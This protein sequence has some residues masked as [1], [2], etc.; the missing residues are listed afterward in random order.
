MQRMLRFNSEFLYAMDGLAIRVR[1]RSEL[2]P[3]DRKIE[4]VAP[5]EIDEALLQSVRLGF[6][7]SKDDAV[8]SALDLLGFGRATQRISS[9]VEDRLALLLEKNRVSFANA[10]VTPAPDAVR[11]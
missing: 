2:S 4:W 10:M 8:S 11:T 7:L 6:S 3:A 1:N 9:A 5:E